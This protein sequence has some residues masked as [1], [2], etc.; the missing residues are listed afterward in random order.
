MVELSPLCPAGGA[1]RRRGCPVS[2]SG[3]QPGDTH[4]ADDGLRRGPSRLGD[5]LPKGRRRQQRTRGHPD[6]ARQGRQRPYRDVVDEAGLAGL[7]R[8]GMQQIIR[9]VVRRVEIDDAHIEIIFRVPPLDGPA[10]PKS[11]SKMTKST[12]R[13]TD[14]CRANL[15]LGDAVAEA[16]ARLR[17]AHRRLSRHDPRRYGRQSYPQKRPSLIFKTDSKDGLHHALSCSRAPRPEWAHHKAAL[18][19]EQQ[20]E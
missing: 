10:R 19:Q 2:G 11:P 20:D 12:Q 7:D 6:R 4:R 14:V 8:T 15:R 17:E 16:R 5:R 3:A 1:K 13:C 9:S 18:K